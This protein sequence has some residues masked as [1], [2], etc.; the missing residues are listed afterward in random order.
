MDRTDG[1]EAAKAG[2]NNT[3]NEDEPA[4][5]EPVATDHEIAPK[6][7]RSIAEDSAL[8]EEIAPTDSLPLAA[9]G[10]D[11]KGPEWSP[12]PTA[13]HPQIAFAGNGSDAKDFQSDDNIEKLSTN[14]Q[15]PSRS[16]SSHGLDHEHTLEKI[17]TAATK[18]KDKFHLSN[19]QVSGP[20]RLFN[21]TNVRARIKWGSDQDEPSAERRRAD[22]DFDLLWR[23][24]DNRKGRGS[25]AVRS[26]LFED[27]AE[28][29]KSMR[30]RKA[31]LHLK[32]MADIL[33][34]MLTTFP[35]WDMAFWS[36][37]SY[38]IGSALFIMDGAFAWVPA[39][40]PENEFEG[41]ETYGVPLCFFFGAIFFQIGATM[42]YFEA[43]NDGSFHG[44]AMRRLMEGH[45]EDQKKMLDEKIHAFFG[46]L[47][48]RSK[49]EDEEAAEKLAHQVDPEAGWKTKDRKER[50][51]SI[52]P[53]AK[54]PGR[55]RGAMD[56]GEAEE[57]QS[58][59][60]FTWRWWP[61]QVLTLHRS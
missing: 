46:S 41:E 42:A 53:P 43:V 38:T 25:I 24:R 56:M 26:S 30:K 22:T 10:V 29:Q 20:S 48:P 52:Y 12:E 2:F 23:S 44:S 49:D 45:E 21:P 3:F 40:F 60:Y 35:Y 16:S 47:N 19:V 54:H 50:P 15:P 51:G 4:A 7:T 36:G 31:I 39:A 11:G 9:E 59:T 8:K 5:R 28:R 18:V 58:S 37:W 55:R 33:K 6:E 27:P 17:K 1:D 57:G 61:R 32:N 34:R 13:R 14:S